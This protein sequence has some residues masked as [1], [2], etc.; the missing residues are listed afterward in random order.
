M[1]QDEVTRRLDKVTRPI[2]HRPTVPP[3]TS[4][5]LKGW[6]AEQLKRLLYCQHLEK[7]GRI[8]S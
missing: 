7:T 3:V 5:R 2:A 1:D 8:R 6:T 4:D